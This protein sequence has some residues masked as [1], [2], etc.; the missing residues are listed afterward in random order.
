MIIINDSMIEE[1]KHILIEFDVK[2]WI[3]IASIV[4][5]LVTA[6]CTALFFYKRQ[7]II[8]KFDRELESHKAKLAKDISRSSTTLEERIK[9]MKEVLRSIAKLNQDVN[10]LRSFNLYECKNNLDFNEGDICNHKCDKN[11]IVHAWDHIAK[12]DKDIHFFEEFVTSV[13]PLLSYSAELILKSYIT[14][15]G[16]MSH[17]AIEKGTTILNDHKENMLAAISVFNE[18]SLCAMI[19]TYDKLVFMYR[20]MLDVPIEEFP[21]DKLSEVIKRNNCINEQVS[22]L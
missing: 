1:I 17:K 21:I 7:S 19:E 6:T 5:S 16:T 9:V 18:D 11:C 2:D 15:V 12:L 4:A 13:M 3:S 10:R 20:F 22:K 8:N 14:L